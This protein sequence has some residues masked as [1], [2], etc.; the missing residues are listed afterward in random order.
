MAD[1]S[2]SITTASAVTCPSCGGRG[3]LP[4]ARGPAANDDDS[5]IMFVAPA[6]FRK[7]QLG[8][9][10]SEIFLF[11]SKCGVAGNIEQTIEEERRSVD[12]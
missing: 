4:T 7:V 12:D 5:H 11:C 3:E 1:Q 6:G 10:A 8:W 9:K 2:T